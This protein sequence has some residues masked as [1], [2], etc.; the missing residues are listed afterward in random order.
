MKKVCVAS[1]CEWTSIGSV[2][3][4]LALQRTLHSM[5]ADVFTLRP[6]RKAD[7]VWKW[8]WCGGKNVKN[9]ILNLHWLVYG[10]KICDGYRRTNEFIEKNVHLLHYRDTVEKEGGIPEADVYIA[11]SDQ[12][13]NPLKIRPE[14]FLDFVPH[15]KKRCSYA[16]SMGVTG[17]PEGS[18]EQF[19]DLIRKFDMI[20]VREEDNVP[21][22]GRITDVPVQVHID[23]VF[24]L[25]R[26]DWMRYASPCRVDKP[27]ILVYALYWDKSLNAQL[28]RLHRQTGMEIIAVSDHLQR[29]YATKRLYDTDVGRFLW[30][31][32]HAQAVVTSSFHG[33]AMA[34]LFNKK[35]AAVVN[36][37]AP[38]RIGCL[39]K[40]LHVDSMA[41]AELSDDCTILYDEVNQ[42]IA[43]E[44]AGSKAYL[45]EVMTAL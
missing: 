13:W 23:P 10:R 22:I 17:I 31:I 19:E 43:D 4:S 20:S 34:I 25:G 42:R 29:V 15:G 36:P 44:A 3:Q 14:F 38:S 5:G 28:R 1:F 21:V 26:E 32:D 12:V 40:R 7:P 33:A 8:R 2:L 18:R 41:I 24:L 9:W 37:K 45:E 27:Y 16:A 30:L 11:G 39:L 6:G 35:L